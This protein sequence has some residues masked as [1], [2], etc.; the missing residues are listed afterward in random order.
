MLIG[1]VESITKERA[2][3]YLALSGG[4]RTYR[5]RRLEGY[6]RDRVENRWKLTHQGIVFDT[7]NVLRDGHHRLKMVSETGLT[8]EFFV[9]RGLDPDA[10]KFIDVGLPR[11]WRDA[12]HMAGIGDY[13]Q[14]L[15]STAK[16]FLGAPNMYTAGNLKISQSDVQEC[17]EEHAEALT[18]GCSWMKGVDGAS[19][20]SRAMI[21]RAYYHCDRE[22]LEYFTRVVRTGLPENPQEDSAAVVYARLLSSTK[23]NSGGGVESERYEKGQS[24][25]TYFMKKQPMTKIY[26]TAADIFPIP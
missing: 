20:A 11:S 16:A 23:R 2:E 3:A 25:I 13:T 1:K 17:I 22:R 7:N 12:F 18:C 24:A 21:A 10:A 5:R 19:R 14:D 26:G 6:K 8:T 9:V 4:N 15:V